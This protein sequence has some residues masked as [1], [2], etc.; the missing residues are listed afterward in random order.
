M[1]LKRADLVNKKLLLAGLQDQG[2]TYLARYISRFFKT[3]L[4]TSHYKTGD[5]DYAMWRGEKVIIPRTSDFVREF[6]FWC[7]IAKRLALLNKI[8]CFIVDDCDLLF[9]THFTSIPQLNDLVI[10]CAHYGLTLIFTT[11]RP[12]DLA[13]RVYEQCEILCLFPIDAPNAIAKYEEYSQGL[14]EVVK[15]LGYGSH[16]FILKFIGQPPVI[17]RV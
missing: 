13:T 2:K 4:Y 12:Q 9:E 10:N 5:K 16:D 8:N 6:P 7:V 11:R 17:A 15:N 14:G 3:M 1:E